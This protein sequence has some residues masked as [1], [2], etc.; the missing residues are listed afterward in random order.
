MSTRVWS[1][2]AV[3]SG[4]ANAARDTARHTF[5]MK[6]LA[7]RD[8]LTGL[9]NR[10]AYNDRLLYSHSEELTAV[11]VDVDDLNQIDDCFGHGGRDRALVG[12]AT[13][14]SRS[15]R[16]NDFVA[17]LAGDEFV[18]LL[19]NARRSQ[20][21]V[22][23]ERIRQAVDLELTDPPVT[24]SVGIETFSGSRPTTLSAAD[25][26]LYAAKALGQGRAA[27]GVA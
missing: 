3:F 21:L 2:P 25:A 26:A 18:V 16:A 19:A 14:L 24:V 11:T 20:A 1:R 27:F 22:I 23:A 7:R 17:R 9:W 6:L 8:P 4:A 10:L 12:V 15:V 5:A 13:I